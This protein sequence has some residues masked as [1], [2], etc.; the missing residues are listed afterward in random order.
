MYN[1]YP[2]VPPG[3]LFLK[4]EVF[5]LRDGVLAL[6]D[7]SLGGGIEQQGPEEFEYS[8]RRKIARCINR[9]R[10]LLECIEEHV[11]PRSTP[12]Q[13][14]N[15]E[16]PF[17]ESARAYLEDSCEVLSNKISELL[18]EI[19]GI[20]LP[21]NL[22]SELKRESDEQRENLN[23]KLTLLCENSRWKTVGRSDII[24]NL[25]SKQLTDT[26]KEALSL[27]L[28]FD[29]GYDKTSFT[30]YVTRNYKW[31]DNDVDKGFAQGVIA[32]YKALANTQYHSIP[33]RYMKVLNEL[34]RNKELVITQADKGGGIIILDKSDYENKMMELLSDGTTYEEKHH[35]YAEE[36]TRKFTSRARQILIKTKKG[37]ELLHLLEENPCIPRM[38]GLP[39]IHK[40]GIPMRPITSGIG[41]A[42]HRL[43][44]RL[45]KPLSNALGSIS[46]AHL[47]NSTDL[48]NRLNNVD[49]KGK[50]MASFDVKALFTSVPKEGAMEA[51]KEA[52]DKITGRYIGNIRDWQWAP[53]SVP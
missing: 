4:K 40:P 41:S 53:H 19:K 37:K 14:T 39:K 45:A 2:N 16:K 51:V 52:V 34:G 22:S 29:T 35:S 24:T 47:K 10:F 20:P 44:K 30:E 6:K 25:S 11:L 15:S 31:K 48:I 42:P 8:A 27:G 32:C 18:S 33:K 23:R 50:E 38:R 17:S 21:N 46:Q 12:K 26:E 43:A 3:D 28:K 36:K 7:A 13:L 49:F 5:G 9:R 1:E